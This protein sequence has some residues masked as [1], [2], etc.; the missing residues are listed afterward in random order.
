MNEI[1][2]SLNRIF[3]A[4]NRWLMFLGGLKN[5]IIITVFAVLIGVI[6]GTIVAIIKVYSYRTNKLKV[7]SKI[8]N[9]YLTVFRG[10]PVVVQLM[11][12]YYIIFSS[13]N[14]AEI[15]I[16]ILAFGINSG[17]YLSETIRSGIMSID[18]G[19]HEAARS[20]GMNEKMTMNYIILPQAFKNILPVIANE[21]IALLKETSIVGYISVID[22]TKAGDLIRARTFEA[23]IPLLFVAFIY[24]ILVMGLTYIQNKI[25]RRL[26]INDKSKKP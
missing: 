11:I 26:N 8:L 2:S 25:E 21:V 22:L 5:T 24:L 13:I 12:W 14:G 17:A 15:P 16:A 10:T 20:L 23:I 1:L 7:V 19:Q 9:I 3:I 18:N 4:D 6:I